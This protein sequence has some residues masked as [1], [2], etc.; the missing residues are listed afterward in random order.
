MKTAV[1]V[2]FVVVMLFCLLLG[3]NALDI[4]INNEE[5]SNDSWESTVL[6]QSDGKKL[7][8][9]LPFAL[10]GHKEIDNIDSV[11]K[12]E[13]FYHQVDDITVAIDHGVMNNSNAEVDFSQ[14]TF[15]MDYG[16]LDDKNCEKIEEKD[17][18]GQKMTYAKISAKK[19][20]YPYTFECFGIH[21]GRNY[22]I[23]TY[24]Y[25]ENNKPSKDLVKKSIESI[26]FH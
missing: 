5:S 8:V 13:K 12:E 10:D 21:D 6:E 26:E 18:H 7:S 16:D 25:N 23:I 17:I 3:S 20:N 1:K 2:L 9:K 14:E 11:R 4:D 15:L 24:I 19:N 22:W